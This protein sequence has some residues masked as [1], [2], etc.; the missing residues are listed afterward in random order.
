VT[1]KGATQREALVN[2]L[3]EIC[4]NSLLAVFTDGGRLFTTSRD[5][6]MF[7]GTRL[8]SLNIPEHIKVDTGNRLEDRLYEIEGALLKLPPEQALSVDKTLGYLRV[9]AEM[10]PFAPFERAYAERARDAWFDTLV[11]Q[12]LITEGDRQAWT[13]FLEDPYN[14]AMRWVPRMKRRS[15]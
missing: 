14:P 4:P 11:D 5:S 13:R 2:I 15:L 6:V 8:D 7:A 3:K 1:I 12:Q 10:H 9:A